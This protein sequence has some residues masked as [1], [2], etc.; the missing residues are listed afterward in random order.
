MRKVAEQGLILG[1]QIRPA[2][3]YHRSGRQILFRHRFI[4]SEKVHLCYY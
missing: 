4:S 3:L 2:L 1:L